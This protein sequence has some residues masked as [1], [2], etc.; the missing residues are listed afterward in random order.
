MCGKDS[1]NIVKGR[2]KR[3]REGK[4]EERKEGERDKYW[5]R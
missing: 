5:I 2:K 3:G 4:R 1:I